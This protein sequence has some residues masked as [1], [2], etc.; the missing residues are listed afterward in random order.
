MKFLIADGNIAACDEINL[1]SLIINPSFRIAQKVWYGYGGIP[2]FSENLRQFNEQA[3]SLRLPFPKAWINQRELLRLTK[4]M[5]NKN[6]YFR[7]GY[8]QF[9]VVWTEENCYSLVTSSA[10]EIFDFPFAN[11]GLLAAIS[12]QKK[13]SRNEFSRFPAF[14]EMTWQAGRAEIHGSPFLQTI[15][16]N[17]C[18]SVCEGAHANIFLIKDHEL[19]VHSA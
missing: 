16:M 11:S 5:L 14:N 1:N 2:L 4:R 9:Q 17:E 8:I 18:L 13:Q 19:I 6:K 15:F 12:S 10:Q 7:S 3:E